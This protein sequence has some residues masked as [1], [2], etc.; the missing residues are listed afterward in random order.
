[1][2]HVVREISNTFSAIILPSSAIMLHIFDPTKII[3][4]SEIIWSDK[5]SNI[6]QYTVFEIF[7][8][9]NVAYYYNH[10]SLVNIL[11]LSLTKHILLSFSN[12]WWC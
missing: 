8:Q 10:Y 6:Y 7:S 5:F 3:D 11:K 4:E 9:D 12:I 1:M 2:I